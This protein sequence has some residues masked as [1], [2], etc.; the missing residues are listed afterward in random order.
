MTPK[1]AAENV[2][3]PDEPLTAE[4]AA[5]M[6]AAALE[7]AADQAYV[8]EAAAAL[9]Q[10]AN[11]WTRLH[12]ALAHAPKTIERAPFT[13]SIDTDSFMRR[14]D[15]AVDDEPGQVEPEP[16]PI[17]YLLVQ[18]EGDYY[19]LCANGPDPIDQ[20]PDRL[21]AVLAISRRRPAGQHVLC[22]L[23]PLDS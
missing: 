4:H 9:V 18:G 5:L 15:F 12:T 8:P 23:I 20:T 13:V 7:M 2:A 1:Q 11:G 10:V 14:V 19:E 3:I 22:K 16:E 21:R 6:A 17:G